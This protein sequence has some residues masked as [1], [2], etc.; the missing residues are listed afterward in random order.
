M[1]AAISP[2]DF[3]NAQPATPAAPS[4]VPS[5]SPDDF[6]NPAPSPGA[7]FGGALTSAANTITPTPSG[8]ANR[9]NADLSNRGQEI[10][11]AYKAQQMGEQGPMLTGVQ[12]LGT[13]AGATSDTIGNLLGS[14]GRSI[15]DNTPQSIKQPITNAI[16]TVTGAANN[17]GQNIVNNSGVGSFIGRQLADASDLKSGNPV[18]GRT[19]SAISNIANL[20]PAVEGIGN[21]VKATPDLADAVI[22]SRLGGL[23]SDAGKTIK[24]NYAASPLASEA[25]GNF[26]IGNNLQAASPEEVNNLKNLAYAKADAEGGQLTPDAVNQAIGKAEAVAPQTPEGKAFA[27]N[28]ATTQAVN[29]LQSLKDKPL[30]L[31]AYE[32][33]DKD[34][35]NRISKETDIGGKLTPDGVN[36]TQIRQHLRDAA[37]NA[38]E[39]D[40]IDGNG[41][42]SYRQAQ[43]L[44]ATKFR[45]DDV[46][47]IFNKADLADNPQSVIKNGFARLVSRGQGGFTDSEWADVNKAA[48][49]GLATGAL[50]LVGSKLL[51]GLVGY[52]AGGL[53]GAAVAE[54]G[55]FGLRKAG[56]ALQ[57]RPAYSVMNKLGS[58]PIVQQMSDQLK[59]TT[60]QDLQ[61][62]FDA[63]KN[64]Q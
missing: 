36:L 60:L 40:L 33:I 18:V 43:Q 17:L 9:M 29:D 24:A 22:N 39:G 58:R 55:A 13:G 8:F 30:S 49:T 1:V 53:P 21:V 27:G 32:E 45:M 28:N 35:T 51:S 25:G 19:I 4:G 57:A 26:S 20:V 41:F 14:V 42:A 62:A 15:A 5:I 16:G 47:S 7:A 63:R 34:L 11:D 59:G 46:Q 23:V 52:S 44:A 3:F 64:A 54:A 61:A 10:S 56:A 12:M 37:A 6:F 50:K 38:G 31:G 48:K 2:D